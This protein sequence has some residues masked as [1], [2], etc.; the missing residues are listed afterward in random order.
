MRRGIGGRSPPPTPRP[1]GAAAE[2][3]A[4]DM[5]GVVSARACAVWSLR[6]LSPAQQPRGDTAGKMCFILPM[7]RLCAFA[8]PDITA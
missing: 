7:P 5:L 1:R 2:A 3:A 6:F 8:L 4:W